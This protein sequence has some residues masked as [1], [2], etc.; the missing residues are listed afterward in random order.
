MSRNSEKRTRFFSIFGRSMS[1]DLLKEFY[2][3]Y[4][5]LSIFTIGLR[6]ST[7]SAFT[8]FRN[9]QQF[10]LWTVAFIFSFGRLKSLHPPLS[11]SRTRLFQ[12]SRWDGQAHSALVSKFPRTRNTNPMSNF[13]RNT[14]STMCSV[15]FRKSQTEVEFCENSGTGSMNGATYFLFQEHFAFSAHFF[16][17]V[18]RLLLLLR[19][20]TTALW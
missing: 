19:F 15:A 8:S 4:H 13:P 12:T 6:S 5:F 11:E 20:F 9:V 14:C 10:A 3:F 18:L 7:W 1:R 16:T 2:H 17:G